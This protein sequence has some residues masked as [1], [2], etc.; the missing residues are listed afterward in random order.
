MAEALWL[1]RPDVLVAYPA[2]SPPPIDERITLMVD[3]VAHLEPLAEGTRVCLDIDAGLWLLG[4]RLK[5]GAKRSPVHTV[6]QAVA[7]AQEIR[8]RGLKL[9]GV[10]AYESQ[11]AGVSDRSRA[12]RAMKRRSVVEL[13]EAARGDRRRAG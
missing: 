1:D 11:V 12:V 9:V 8:R 5:F 13:V 10:M 4:D 3:C 2:A 7:M 6:E